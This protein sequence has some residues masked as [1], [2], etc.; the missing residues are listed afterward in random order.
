M[1]L[2]YAGEVT[3]SGDYIMI[4]CFKGKARAALAR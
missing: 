1:W 4:R 3:N 2:K